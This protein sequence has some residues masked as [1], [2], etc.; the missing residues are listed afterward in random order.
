MSFSAFTIQ[1]GSYKEDRSA[2][3]IRDEQT[4]TDKL[5]FSPNFPK[6]LV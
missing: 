3:L 1:G 4:E 6:S 2:L 5:G